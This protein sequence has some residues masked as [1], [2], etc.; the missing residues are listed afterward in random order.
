MQRSVPYTLAFVAAVCVVCSVF[1]S[2]SVVL[3]KERQKRNIV[4]ERQRNVLLAA[5]LLARGE[6]VSA[7]GIVETFKKNVRPRVIVLKTGEYDDTIDP[8]SF[9]QQA[10][11][12]GPS[13]EAAPE[14]AARV[15]RLPKYAV[16]YEILKDGRIDAI[17]LPIEGMGLWSTLYGYIAVAADTATVRGIT[18]YQH[19]ETPGLGGEVENAKWQLLWENRKVYD[20]AWTPKIT[21][22]K[23]KAG[24]AA[25]DPYHVDGL[26]GATMTS[27][28][29]TNMIA[30]WFGDSGFGPYLK[31]IREGRN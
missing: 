30:F 4:L 2:G 8:N 3:L 11:A 10:A 5:G 15:R 1:V 27:R 31:R 20:E 9:D 29:V 24:P 16:I 14:N 21:V 12:K 22:I 6:R 23:G 25:Q 28:G 7:K 13:S 18:Y 19:G 17:A 26:S